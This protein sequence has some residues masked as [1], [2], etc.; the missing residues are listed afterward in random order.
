MLL[1]CVWFIVQE[2]TSKLL[3]EWNALSTLYLSP[4]DS[5]ATQLAHIAQL[6]ET[7]CKRVTMDSKCVGTSD[8]PDVVPPILQ[9]GAK[10]PVQC[11]RV[12]VEAE[13]QTDAI[14]EDVQV[15]KVHAEVQTGAADAE[16]QTGAMDAEVQ[17]GTVATED[18]NQVAGEPETEE[19]EEGLPDIVESLLEPQ[20]LDKMVEIANKELNRSSQSTHGML[21]TEVLRILCRL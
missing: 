19:P 5:M 16:V 6:L 12:T 17:T 14:I 15:T 2:L 1:I 11:A 9:E 3:Y 13:V 4:H 10:E 20:N 8:D 7:K 18:Q 21:S